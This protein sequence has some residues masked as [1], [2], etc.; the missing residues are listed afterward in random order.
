MNNLK[1]VENCPKDLKNSL[2]KSLERLEEKV[3]H[4]R[5]LENITEQ[6]LNILTNPRNLD[7]G[8]EKICKAEDNSNLTFIGLFDNVNTQ[9][10]K[11]LNQIEEN[12]ETIKNYLI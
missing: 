4:S 1:N 9:L 7:S 12:L 2:M 10:E 6:I 11:S 5:R 8:G 3:Y